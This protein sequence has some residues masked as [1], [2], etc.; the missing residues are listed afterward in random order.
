MRLEITEVNNAAG[1]ARDAKVATE[2]ALG[3]FSG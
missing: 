3:N 2:P 1:A